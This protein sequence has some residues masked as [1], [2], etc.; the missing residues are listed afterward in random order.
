LFLAANWFD[1]GNPLP[2]L[3]HFTHPALV[4]LCQIAFPARIFSDESI[5]KYI[6]RLGLVKDSKHPLSTCYAKGDALHIR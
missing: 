5:R 2:D 6:K 1:S 3:C 4:N